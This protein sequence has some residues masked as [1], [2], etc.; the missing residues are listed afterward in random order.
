M[1]RQH[2]DTTSAGSTAQHSR[3]GGGEDG[4]QPKAMTIFTAYVTRGARTSKMRGLLPGLPANDCHLLRAESRYSG[5]SVV[6]ALTVFAAGCS[7]ESPCNHT[8]LTPP[9]K[10]PH[11]YACAWPGLGLCWA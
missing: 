11:D 5:L 4:G 3:G 2:S 1:P 9:P 8:T 6:A 7:R 10:L